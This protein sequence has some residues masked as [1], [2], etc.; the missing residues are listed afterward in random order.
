[1]TITNCQVCGFIYDEWQGDVYNGVPKGVPLCDLAGSLCGKCAMQGERHAKQSAAPYK[2]MEAANYE[3][4]AGKAGM[5]FYC[6]L[7]E[8]HEDAHLLEIGAG[9]GRIAVDLCKQG[10]RVT[11]IDTSADMLKIARKKAK[12]FLKETPD[13][14][15]LIEMDAMELEFE[16]TFSHCILPDG[17]IQHFTETHEQKALLKKVRNSLRDGGLIA[18]DII[19]PPVS[20]QWQVSKRKRMM[21]DKQMALDVTGSTSLA[22]QLYRYEALFEKFIGGVSEERYKVERE[23]SLMLPKELALL[24]ES[25]GFEVTSMIQNYDLSKKPLW[26][27]VCLHKTPRGTEPELDLTW[28]DYEEGEVQ[29]LRNYVWRGGG[30]PFEGALSEEHAGETSYWTIIAKK[31]R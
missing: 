14:L 29:P 19:L 23:L 13:L 12:A 3:I 21:N 2:G 1:M 18:V 31:V 16:E 17:I 9:T 28:K 15:S 10:W 24:V 26:D 7:F 30:Y 20:A 8:Q 4:F 22:R 11:G 27:T 25:E 5:A 6:E